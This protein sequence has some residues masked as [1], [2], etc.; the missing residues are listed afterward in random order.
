MYSYVEP[1]LILRSGTYVYRNLLRL[2]C[3]C[4]FMCVC[5]HIYMHAHTHTH[6][7]VPQLMLGICSI[8]AELNSKIM[9]SLTI[10]SIKINVVGG[11]AFLLQ[12]FS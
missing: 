9:Y 7:S 12:L 10:F 11:G 5:M 8:K 3:V 2:V 1:Y 4:V 6:I